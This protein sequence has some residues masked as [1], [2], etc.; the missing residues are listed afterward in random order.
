[1]AGGGTCPA[2]GLLAGLADGALHAR[3]SRPTI[4][5]SPTASRPS[6]LSRRRWRSRRSPAR[7]ASSTSNARRHAGSLPA[8]GVHEFEPG[9]DDRG[10][11][12]IPPHLFVF[13]RDGRLVAAPRARRP[14]GAPWRASTST[15]SRHSYRPHPRGPADYRAEAASITSGDRAAPM[16]CSGPRAAARPRCSTSSPASSCRPAGS[17]LFD[18]KDVTRLPTEQRNIAQVFQFP[19][20]YDTMTVCENLAFPL[21]NRGVPRAEIDARVAR[22]RRACSI[23]R[24]SEPHGRAASPP[25]PSRRSR[26]AAAWCAPTSA[27]ILF[28][29]PLTVIDPHLKWELRSQAEG[30]C[31]A[32]STITMIY[33]THDQT[34]ALTFAD[35][36]VVMH[37]GEIVQIG[38]PAGAVRA[39]RP[40]LRR[41]F[42]RLARHERAAGRRSTARRRGSAATP[43]ELGAR[44]TA[45]CRPARASSSASGPNS[46]ALAP[47]T[48][49][50]RSS[51]AARRRSRPPQDR[52]R[53]RSTRPHDRGAG[54]ARTPRSPPTAQRLRLRSGADPRLCR[55]PAASSGRRPDGQDPSTTGPGSWCCRSR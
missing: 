23:S 47:A 10:P 46:C 12:S 1:M 43:I 2:G 25:T 50:C 31:T 4:S 45:A 52:A 30:S 28:D 21:R 29:E 14:E 32:R 51:V 9:A 5:L 53:A 54:A 17:V 18:G 44:P 33:V 41:L 37:D 40:H 39:A 6:C 34:E 27:A 35:K 36:V 38:T 42:H 19:V 8:P 20:I 3:L 15:T 48:A 22:D 24:R 13:D 16:R 7:R 55:R 26:S 49:A 11:C